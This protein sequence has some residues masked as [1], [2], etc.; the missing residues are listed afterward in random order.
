M[1]R[2]PKLFVLMLAGSLALFAGIPAALAQTS[3][4]A[5]KATINFLQGDTPPPILDPTDPSDPYDPDPDDPTD[6]Q[7]PPTGETGPLTLDYVSSVHF[8]SQEIAG[9]TMVY[10]STVLRPFIQISDRRGTAAGWTVTAQ[11]SGFADENGTPSLEGAKLIFRNGEAVSPNNVAPPTPSTLVELYT[12]GEAATVVTAAPGTGVATWITRWFPST[13]GETNDNVTLEVPGGT[14]R[15][16]EHTA[17][18][19]WTLTDAPGQ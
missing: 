16:G 9:T 4:G 1:R 17:T 7:D 19:T 5:S 18:I 2:L 6:P 14:A 12:G 10:E 8:G 3:T 11:A 15:T 13:A